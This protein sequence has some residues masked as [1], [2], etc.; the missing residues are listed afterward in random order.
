MERRRWIGLSASHSR[1]DVVQSNFH[2]IC[3]ANRDCGGSIIAKLKLHTS[4]DWRQA[5]H[6]H[7]D[8]GI[9]HKWYRRRPNQID[10]NCFYSHWFSVGLIIMYYLFLHRASQQRLYLYYCRCSNSTLHFYCIALWPVWVCAHNIRLCDQPLHHWMTSRHNAM[11]HECSRE[12]VCEVKLEREFAGCKLLW[13]TDWQI[14]HSCVVYPIVCCRLVSINFLQN[15]H[16]YTI[17]RRR[18]H[19]N[20]AI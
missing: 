20:T 5:A 15:A 9:R 4:H 13:L 10:N 19:A 7:R 14:R 8:H 11:P 12:I 3:I 18:C 16:S 17:R 2:W 6:T 1:T